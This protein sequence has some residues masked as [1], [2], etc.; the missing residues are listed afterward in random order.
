MY[1]TYI[2]Y[3]P[4][5]E[6]IY[7]GFTSDIEKRILSHNELSKKGWTQRYR[8]WELVYTEEF[9]DKSTAMRREKSLKTAQGRKFAW[10]KVA[11]YQE[12]KNK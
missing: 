12:N 11:E 5:Y 10:T 6:K 4:D 8:P 7:I 9:T 2:L 1:T 3:S